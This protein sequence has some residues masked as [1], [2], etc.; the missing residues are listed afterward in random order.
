MDQSRGCGVAHTAAAAEA[1]A[2]CS[3]IGDRV[4]G[5][6]SGSGSAR[7]IAHHNQARPLELNSEAKLIRR[8]LY[9]KDFNAKHLSRGARPVCNTL[10]ET[11][12]FQRHTKFVRLLRKYSASLIFLAVVP[13]E[14][15][16]ELKSKGKLTSLNIFKGLQCKKT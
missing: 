7:P 1:A 3:R 6:S 16:L 12:V 14:R 2:L 5:P 13:A 4:G 11:S 8:S 9:L 15:P 10:Y